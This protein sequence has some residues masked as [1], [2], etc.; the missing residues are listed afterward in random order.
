MS[1]LHLLAATTLS[2]CLH[3]ADN[4]T[5]LQV[6]TSTVN[7]DYERTYIALPMIMVHG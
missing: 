6:R 7:Y 4:M 5:A 2:L 3:D 1:G